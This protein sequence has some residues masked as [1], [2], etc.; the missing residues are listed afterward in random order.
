MHH[1]QSHQNKFHTDTL[2]A[3][4]AKFASLTDYESVSQADRDL[5]E[6]F[7]TLYKNSNKGIKG[8]GKHRK[9]EPVNQQPAHTS[10]N[11]LPPR[12]V[13]T[14]SPALPQRLHTPLPVQQP[15]PYHG[16]SHPAAY[17]MS[18]PSMLVQVAPRAPHPSYELYDVEA[19]SIAST[20]PTSS[21]AGPLYDEDHS[22]ELAFGDRIY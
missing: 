3:L 4:T 22:R 8:R 12:F 15:L 2:A 10:S 20:A 18:R 1:S 16:F 19:A 13:S 11:A 9:V 21:S 14:S 6:Y 7:A 5:W 17:S